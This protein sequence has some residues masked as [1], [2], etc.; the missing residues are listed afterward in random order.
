MKE[1]E[2]RAGS[3]AGTVKQRRSGR[4]QRQIPIMLL[5][6][7]AEGRVFSEEARTVVIS[8]YG[9]GIVS[10]HKLTAEQEVTM[11]V[12]DTGQEAEVRVVGEI[13]QQAGEHTYGVAFVDESIDFW[14]VEF[15]EPPAW[16]EERLPVLTLECG[17]C[18]GVAEVMNGDFEYDVC[19]IHGGLARFCGECGLLT[20]WRKPT[21]TVESKRRLK[22]GK[23]SLREETREAIALA[24]W[25]APPTERAVAI[26]EPVDRRSRIRVKVNFFACVRSEQ[27]GE[28]VV[29]CVDMSKG[30]VSFRARQRYEKD[31]KVQVAVPFA[32]EEREAPAIFVR[33][34]IA[35]ARAEGNGGWR[36]GVEFLK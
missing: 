17:G 20:V 4:I 10:A 30:G 25:V 1:D 15:P 6:S 12:A 21:G 33:A 18:Q 13:G 24:E 9:A 2:G 3:T 28:E 19:A 29:P 31:M 32:A 34:R 14:R 8:R 22:M 16:Q 36:C 35:H 26:A 7:D 23:K 27:F 5:G 11:R